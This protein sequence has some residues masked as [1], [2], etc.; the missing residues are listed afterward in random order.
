MKTLYIDVYF[1][2]NFTVDI[3]AVF[4]AARIMHVKINM[5]KLLFSGILGALFA[6]IELFLN[7]SVL[8]IAFASLFLFML[9]YISCKSVSPSRKIK[10]LLSFYIAAFLI[11]G[12][13]DF[14]YGLMDRYVS[15]LLIEA[16]GSTNRKAIIF[17]LII[18]LIIGVLRLFIMVFSESINEKSSHIRIELDGKSLEIEALI[19]TGNLVRDPM[20]MNPVIFIKRK[21]AENIISSDIIDLNDIDRLGSDFRKRIRLIPVTRNSQTHVMIGLRVDKVYLIKDDFKE[22]ID[23]T[24]VIDKEEGTYGGFY[25]LAPYVSVCNDA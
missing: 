10:F 7:N 11:G 25:A 21:S 9:C 8:H 16:S 19:D 6:T 17:S 24:I 23:A 20:N 15:D 12:I 14:L 2:I 22:E 4:I 13:V 5:I 3:L 1:M 18:L